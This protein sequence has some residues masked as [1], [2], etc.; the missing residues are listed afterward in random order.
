MACLEPFT[1]L[2][3]WKKCNICLSVSRERLIRIQFRIMDLHWFSSLNRI[4]IHS[5]D[6]KP[7]KPMLITF[8]SYIYIIFQGK[9]SHKKSQNSSNY[10]F[11]YYFLLDDPD[12]YL[13]LMDPDPW[14]PKTYGSYGS[15]SATLAWRQWENNDSCY[16]PVPDPDLSLDLD[17]LRADAEG[18]GRGQLLFTRLLA[19]RRFQLRGGGGGSGQLLLL[20]RLWWRV[21]EKCKVVNSLADP[22][23]FWPLDPGFGIRNWGWATGSYF[24]ELKNN[25]LG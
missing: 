14:G 1:W 12:P 5:E 16:I 20:L 4:R 9:K 8:G 25:F 24:R 17:P 11:S 23:P 22:V 13:V 6:P 3:N 15:G 7:L 21:L 19:R 18:G 2:T 10:G